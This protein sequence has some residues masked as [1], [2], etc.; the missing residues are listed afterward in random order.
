MNQNQ[1]WIEQPSLIIFFFA[2]VYRDSVDLWFSLWW[3][4]L[5]R[6]KRRAITRMLKTNCD[7]NRNSIEASSTFS[8]CV[9][10]SLFLLHNLFWFCAWEKKEGEE[11]ELGIG[12]REKWSDLRAEEELEL[13]FQI[14]FLPENLTNVYRNFAF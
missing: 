14:L 3:I 2:F 11:I 4:P 5:V 9:L 10:C 6:A 8:L 7:E 12:L 13:N 1:R